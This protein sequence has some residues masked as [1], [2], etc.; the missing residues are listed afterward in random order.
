MVARLKNLGMRLERVGDC[1][2]QM[3][4]NYCDRVGIRSTNKLKNSSKDE[5]SD[6]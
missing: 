4:S 6:Y 3:N 2:Q 5:L 1:K